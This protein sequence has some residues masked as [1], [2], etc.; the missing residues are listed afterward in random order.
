[1]GSSSAPK[2]QILSPEFRR[3]KP[4]AVLPKDSRRLSGSMVRMR[5]SS[6]FLTSSLTAISS[7]VGRSWIT[8]SKRRWERSV[9]KR[10]FEWT[11]RRCIEGITVVGTSRYCCCIARDWVVRGCKRGCSKPPDSM[12][13]GWNGCSLSGPQDKWT[14]DKHTRLTFRHANLI[15]ILQEQGLKDTNIVVQIVF[16]FTQWRF[17]P[18]VDGKRK[19]RYHVRSEWWPLKRWVTYSSTTVSIHWQASSAPIGRVACIETLI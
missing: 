17:R 12:G 3:L 10:C 4:F 6:N 7:W 13:D 1:M 18:R 5:R 15:T 8:N 9:T 14:P 2:R 11:W 16:I 19:P